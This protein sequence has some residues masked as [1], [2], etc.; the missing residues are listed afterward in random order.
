MSVAKVV[1][2]VCDLCDEA[3]QT[4][5]LHSVTEA[6]EDARALGWKRQGGIDICPLHITEREVGSPDV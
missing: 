2:L 6:R 4:V 5:G 1:Y 3:Q